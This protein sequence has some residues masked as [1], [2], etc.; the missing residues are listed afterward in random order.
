[1]GAHRYLNNRLGIFRPRG[2][3]FVRL[4]VCPTPPIFSSTYGGALVGQLTD[5]WHQMSNCDQYILFLCCCIVCRMSYPS[6][7][8]CVT[9]CESAG[10]KNAQYSVTGTAHTVKNTSLDTS[11]YIP[12]IL[13]LM[14]VAYWWDVFYTTSEKSSY[15]CPS[16][17][18]V[19]LPPS[20]YG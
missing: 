12:Y 1:M 13:V 20:V 9:P 5:R 16:C 15:L 14:I 8:L 10:L 17:L 7:P 4:P 2:G 3:G 6:R 19:V 18:Y 11:T